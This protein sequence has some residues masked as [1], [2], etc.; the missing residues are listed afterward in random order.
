MVSY[1]FNAEN[2]II[3]CYVFL[4]AVMIYSR[5]T[6]FPFSLYSTFVI[7]ARHGINK[8]TLALFFKDQLKII[9]LSVIIGPPIVA[10]IIY[11]VQIG[12]P[13]L[14]IYLWTFMFVLALV[15]MTVYPIL[16]GPLFNK[17]TPL[18]NGE[19]RTKIETLASSLNFPLKKLFVFDGST[20]SIHCNAYMIG[21]FKNERIVLY[22]TLIQQ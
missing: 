7:E 14:A 22:D 4:G 15:V 5:I 17:F 13:Y 20:R 11:I 2:E 6:D 16:I 3:H 21:F 12:G 1:G 8:Q 18:P 9:L 19:L 10:A